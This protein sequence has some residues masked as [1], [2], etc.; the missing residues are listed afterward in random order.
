VLLF[1]VSNSGGK[2]SS[3]VTLSALQRQE[4]KSVGVC[5]FALH[6]FLI[7]LELPLNMKTG[8]SNK[9]KQANYSTS[10]LHKKS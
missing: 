4:E 8:A 7:R 3:C 9:W 2:S 5:L 10:H 6:A 1:D